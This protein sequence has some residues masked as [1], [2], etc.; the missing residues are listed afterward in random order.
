M[1]LGLSLGVTDKHAI[2]GKLIGLAKPGGGLLPIL[3]G[4]CVRKLVGR[5]MMASVALRLADFF[6]GSH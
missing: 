4:D 5:L 6:L 2:G 3:V 1:A